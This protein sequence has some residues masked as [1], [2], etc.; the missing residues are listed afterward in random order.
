[1]SSSLFNRFQYLPTVGCCLFLIL[2][3]ISSVKFPGGSQADITAAGYS[4]TNNYLCDVIASKSHNGLEHPYYKSGLAAMICL[5]GGVSMFFFF[6]TDWMKVK[7][8]WRFIIKWMGL[9]SMICAMLIFTDLHNI[10]IAIASILALPALLGVFITL[11]RKQF[12]SYFFAGV[13]ILILLLI[14][15][16]IYY[17]DYMEHWLP[18]I[19]KISVLC[20]I[21]W[22]VS[23]NRK[24][25]KLNSDLHIFSKF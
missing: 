2:I 21:L 5:C 12:F 17:T 14:N 6:F 3:T 15:N 16:V 20:V 19:Q 24:F 7:G 4:W 13:L 25:V 22:L 10:M 8:A 18:Q 9:I 23:M 1:M 11:Y